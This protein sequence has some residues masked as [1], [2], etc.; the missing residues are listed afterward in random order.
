MLLADLELVKDCEV[1]VA[2]N[3]FIRVNSPA[4]NFRLPLNTRKD[5]ME[6]DE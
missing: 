6:N 4:E 3:N 1:R 5:A 2:L